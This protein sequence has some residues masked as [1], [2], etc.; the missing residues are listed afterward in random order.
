MSF[1]RLFDDTNF[2][3]FYVSSANEIVTDPYEEDGKFRKDVRYYR[4]LTKVDLGKEEQCSQLLELF[5][6]KLLKRT[7]CVLKVIGEVETPSSVEDFLTSLCDMSH[8]IRAD[9][10]KNV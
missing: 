2:K 9:G 1:R 5:G 10:E 8:M 3:G 4:T 7:V 6:E